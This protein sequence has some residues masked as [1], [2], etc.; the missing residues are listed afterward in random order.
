M[1][2]SLSDFEPSYVLM[3]FTEE[4]KRKRGPAILRGYE[5]MN[6]AQFKA[7]HAVF[8]ETKLFR[9]WTVRGLLLVKDEAKDQ[10]KEDY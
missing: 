5:H 2:D 9:G 6:R 10:A 4:A 3:C 8:G 1:T 7:L